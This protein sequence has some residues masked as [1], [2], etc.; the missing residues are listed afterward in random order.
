MIIII[1]IIIIIIIII[2]TIST[3]HC[4]ADQ[5]NLRLICDDSCYIIPET[6]LSLNF[7]LRYHISPKRL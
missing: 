4:P 5:S 2:I 6:L 1:V 3:I 7:N